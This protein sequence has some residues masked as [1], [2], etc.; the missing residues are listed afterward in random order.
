M[1][2][3]KVINHIGNKTIEIPNLG[4]WKKQEG[5]RNKFIKV[6]VNDG[7]VCLINTPGK[8]YIV[9]EERWNHIYNLYHDPNNLAYRMNVGFYANKKRANRNLDPYIATIVH[10]FEGQ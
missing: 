8:S 10:Y 1:T 9:S 5:V 7:V 3:Q 4:Q 2:Y 6:M